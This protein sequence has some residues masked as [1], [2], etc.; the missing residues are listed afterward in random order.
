LNQNIVEHLLEI[1]KYFNDWSQCYLLELLLNYDPPQEHVFAVLVRSIFLRY[2]NCA[3]SFNHFQ[4]NILDDRLKH[5]NA[6]VVLGVIKLFLKYTQNMPEVYLQVFLR[7]KE[8]L[9]TLMAATIPE[10]ELVLLSHIKILAERSDTAFQDQYKRFYCR[11]SDPLYIKLIK[12][13][14][15]L[16]MSNEVNMHD[17]VTELTYVCF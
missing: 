3:H 7:V 14:I 1:F 11:Q 13:D 5:P 9:I 15:L 2:L 12:L 17:I 4:Q 16:L 10:L 6:G 8:P